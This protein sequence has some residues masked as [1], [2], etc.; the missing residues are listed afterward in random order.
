MAKQIV[1]ADD[2][3]DQLMK[4]KKPGESFSNLIRRLID[5]LPDEITSS[6]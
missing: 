4:M 1:V 5:C 2:I 3:Y 6:K